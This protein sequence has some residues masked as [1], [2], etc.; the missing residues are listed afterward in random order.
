MCGTEPRQGVDVEICESL[1]APLFIP[2]PQ[3]DASNTS[4]CFYICMHL[5]RWYWRDLSLDRKFVAFKML[6]K[7]FSNTHKTTKDQHFLQY[8]QTIIRSSNC[9]RLLF[10]SIWKEILLTSPF[11]RDIVESFWELLHLV[12]I[13]QTG[14]W[15]SFWS[16]CTNVSFKSFFSLWHSKTN[17]FFLS[18]NCFKKQA[19]ES[20]QN[21]T[22]CQIFRHC[23][24]S[25]CYLAE[26]DLLYM[27][28]TAPI[29]KRCELHFFSRPEAWKRN[30]ALLFLQQI[31]P[32]CWY[33]TAQSSQ[34]EWTALS[35][36]IVSAYKPTVLESTSI[37]PLNLAITCNQCRI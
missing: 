3:I 16:M 22:E 32:G 24:T 29:C 2:A 37:F 31:L 30:L 14:S 4:Y 15:F 21:Q 35:A 27:Q 20:T 34:S 33:W 7:T 12:Y 6:L 11:F 36:V 26:S 1:I 19:N 25:S 8:L 5:Y 10:H 13:T 18:T 28:N 23:I 17:F 9:K